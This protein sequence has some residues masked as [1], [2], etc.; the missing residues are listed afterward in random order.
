[1]DCYFGRITLESVSMS[2]IKNFLKETS[3]KYFYCIEG[4]GTP[5][6]HCHFYIE[7]KECKSKVL[8]KLW[9]PKY[10]KEIVLQRT[11]IDIKQAE[12][13]HLPYINLE[14]QTSKQ[15]CIKKDIEWRKQNNIPDFEKN[16]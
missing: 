14:K 5:N 16:W 2:S 9:R 7:T 3:P 12:A 8:D 1:M 11:F 6:P 10:V 13:Q 15:E 4:L